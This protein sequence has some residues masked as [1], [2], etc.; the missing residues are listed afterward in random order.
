M[1]EI[2]D[3]KLDLLLDNNRRIDRGIDEEDKRCDSF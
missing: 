2:Y 3:G 1:E